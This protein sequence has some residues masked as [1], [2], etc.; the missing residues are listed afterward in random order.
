MTTLFPAKVG[1]A[2]ITIQLS[3]FIRRNNTILLAIQQH[4]DALLHPGCCPKDRNSFLEF[5]THDAIEW[6][7]LR[8]RDQ[9]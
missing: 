6:Q 8:F 4:L 3:A 5:D 9:P 1:R 7:Y 2:F